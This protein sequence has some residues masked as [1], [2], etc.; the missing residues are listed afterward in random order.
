M[1]FCHKKICCMFLK[2]FSEPLLES[3]PQVFIL[4]TLLIISSNQPNLIQ[5]SSET[6]FYLT[7][8]S[9]LISCSFG[10]TQFLKIGPC[11]L[12]EGYGIGFVNIKKIGSLTDL[13]PDHVE[14]L[15]SYDVILLNLPNTVN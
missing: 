11:R 4:G 10:I 2:F 14:Q 5:G 15:L 8:F 3:L 12:I 13:M 9:S 7:L 1:K 6:L